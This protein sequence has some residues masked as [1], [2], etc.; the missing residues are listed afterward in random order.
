MVETPG[1]KDIKVSPKNVAEWK[2]YLST[3]Q[4]DLAVYQ[5]IFSLRQE[6]EKPEDWIKTKELAKQELKDIPEDIVPK[7]FE[8]LEPYLNALPSG[9]SKKHITRGLVNSLIISQDPWVKNLDAAERFIGI[10]GGTFSDIGTSV[11]GRYGEA[12]RFSGHAEA[13]AFLFGQITE[14][15]LPPNLLKLS[16]LAIAAHTHYTKNIEIKRTVDGKE[17]VIIKKTYD[18]ALDEQ[19]NKA[20]IWLS[21]WADRLDSQGIQFFIRHALTKAEPTEDYDQ[22]GWHEIKENEQEDF[23]HHFDPKMRTE[24]F[25]HGRNTLEHM[26][27]FRNSAVEKSVYSQFDTPYFRNELIRPNA[28]EQV[29]L[30]EEVLKDPPDLP[31]KEINEKFETFYDMCRR[32]D[33]SSNVEIVI[34]LFKRKFPSLS[35]EQLSHWANGFAVLPRLYD[36]MLLRVENKLQETNSNQDQS[37]VFKE[38]SKFALQKLE[39]LKA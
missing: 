4:A 22:E 13:G 33:G 5:N 30:T 23:N 31:D 2:N 25:A 18:D 32:V 11:V 27:M 10:I 7:L 3:P 19:G 24:D 9:F 20:G 21:R 17:E 16:Q 37:G 35:K 6:V 1:S 38:A 34:G 36:Q 28:D 39:A 8:R 26:T 14:D 15:L 29:E 12:K